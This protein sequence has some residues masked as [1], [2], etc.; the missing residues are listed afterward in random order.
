MSLPQAVRRRRRSCAAALAGDERHPWQPFDL[1]EVERRH[2]QPMVLGCLLVGVL[3]VEV[4]IL[5][6]EPHGAIDVPEDVAVGPQG[7]GEDF[8]RVTPRVDVGRLHVRE[9]GGDPEV[10]RGRPEIC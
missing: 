2:L 8:A 6:A 3:L 10:A 7:I 9:V 5:G 4:G 1:K